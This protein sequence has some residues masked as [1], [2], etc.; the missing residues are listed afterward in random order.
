VA[1]Q[2]TAHNTIIHYDSDPAPKQDPC[3]ILVNRPQE[4]CAAQLNFRRISL[5]TLQETIAA[6]KENR[7]AIDARQ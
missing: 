5:R 2:P 4:D 6:K 3:H 7:I 1:K